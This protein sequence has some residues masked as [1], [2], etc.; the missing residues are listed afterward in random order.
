MT[1]ENEIICDNYEIYYASLINKLKE[2]LQW[3]LQDL[4]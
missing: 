1:T 2:N 4:G 3:K